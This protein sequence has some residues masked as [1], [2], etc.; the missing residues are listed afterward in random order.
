LRVCGGVKPGRRRV[1]MGDM[2]A[3]MRERV[4]LA[5]R[6]LRRARRGDDYG[7]TVFSSELEDLLRRASGHGIGIDDEDPA[8]ARGGARV[9]EGRANRTAE[10]VARGI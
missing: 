1:V 5:R 7:V 4:G 6:N 10:G 3:N 2:A 9:E 8:E